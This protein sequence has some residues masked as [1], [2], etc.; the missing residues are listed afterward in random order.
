MDSD[1]LK[2]GA[3]FLVRKTDGKVFRVTFL[4]HWSEIE[5]ADGETDYVK[6]Y[7]FSAEG[8]LMVSANKGFTYIKKG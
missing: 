4:A 7:G 3:P 5:S 8:D 2:V 6:C 1:F